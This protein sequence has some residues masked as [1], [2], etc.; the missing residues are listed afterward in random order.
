LER[1]V[2]FYGRLLEAD[3]KSLKSVASDRSNP[4]PRS[5]PGSLPSPSSGLQQAAHR[6]PAINGYE[7]NVNRTED[8]NAKSCILWGKIITEWDDY[9]RRNAK[10]LRV[11]G[12][13]VCLVR[14]QCA[15][16]E[17]SLGCCLIT[18]STTNA[19]FQMS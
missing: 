11:R 8:Y 12:V 5:S 16:F 14:G 15:I 9:R 19:F 6:A 1:F 10:Q 2:C 3:R 7:S 17:H 4:S 18:T 13:R